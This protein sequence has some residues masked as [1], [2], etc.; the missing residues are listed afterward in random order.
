MRDDTLPLSI[1]TV[2]GLAII[3]LPAL[4]LVALGYA[5]YGLSHGGCHHDKGT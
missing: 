2:V 3:G 1:W 5:L 4:P